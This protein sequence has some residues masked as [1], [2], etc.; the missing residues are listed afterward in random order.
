MKN[1][2]G[3]GILCRNCTQTIGEYIPKGVLVEDFCKIKTCSV[4][5]CEGFLERGCFY[6]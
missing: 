6:E 4:C 5:G 3:M 2:Y 1:R